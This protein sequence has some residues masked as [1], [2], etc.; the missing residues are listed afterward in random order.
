MKTTLCVLLVSC[1]AGLAETPPIPSA[2]ELGLP[3]TSPWVIAK[4][5]VPAG[6]VQEA[7]IRSVIQQRGRH[8]W[9]YTPPGFDRTRTA[10]YDLLVAFDGAEYVDLIPV[11]VILDN[12]LAAGKIQPTVA[13]LIE[14]GRGVERLSDLAN[15]APFA[16][17][18]AKELVPWMRSNWNATGD[19]GRTILT[20]SS[21]GGLAS[22]YAAL[23]HPEVFGNV[24]AQSGAFWRGNDAS[25]EPP[26]E[27]LTAQYKRHKKMPVAFWME[28][29]GRETQRVLRGAGPVAVEANR[30]LRDVLGA[31]GYPVFYTE[32][33]GGDHE[34]GHWR[35]QLAEG[36]LW[37]T[38]RW[39]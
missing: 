4:E 18:L 7:D 5:G 31:K 11:P 34:P 12:L 6:K 35:N 8:V 2:R 10:P 13:V 28:M 9:I 21:A 25:N 33:E 36:I 24:L 26:Y 39:K 19:P 20:G 30:R 27:W 22:A 38:A 1:T 29:G 15:R 23:K 17:F 16:E 37:L 32:V 3:S 14:N